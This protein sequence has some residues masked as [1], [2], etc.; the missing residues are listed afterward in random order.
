M[1]REQPME[2]ILQQV[3]MQ[4]S[5]FEEGFMSILYHYCGEQAFFSILQNQIIRLSDITKSND[6]N[7][8]KTIYLLYKEQLQKV[9]EK[10][11]RVDA[12]INRIDTKSCWCFCLSEQ[13]DLLSQWRGY[14]DDGAGYNI[15]FD[16]DIIDEA[17]KKIKSCLDIELKRVKYL[18]SLSKDNLFPFDDRFELAV[19]ALAAEYKTSFFSEEKEWRIIGSSEQLAFWSEKQEE[20]TEYIKDFGAS[21]HFKVGFLSNMKSFIEIPFSLLNN[22][23]R[24]IVIG[25][26]NK[27]TILDVRRYLVHT[28]LLASLT[29]KSIMVSKSIGSFR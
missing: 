5:I 11:S 7:E 4:G 8:L 21:E 14:A 22:P 2:G 29:D 20:Y 24:E 6:K 12:A 9:G 17:L 26:K 19:Y 1:F 27:A 13:R 23:V 18:S 16:G 28:G 15:G 10:T 3:S 25:P